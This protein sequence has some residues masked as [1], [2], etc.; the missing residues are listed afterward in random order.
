D[1]R[2]WVYFSARP[3]APVI[4][5]HRLLGPSD[6]SLGAEIEGRI[7]L[8]GTSAV[9]LRDLVSTPL[10]SGLPGVLV[11]AE[12]G[13]QIV[14]GEFITRPDWAPGLEVTAAIGLS[15]LLLAFLPWLTTLANA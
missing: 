14:S 5:V 11:H 9:G 13:D 10:G 15:L 6:P 12:I 3:A 4:P 2:I 1:G 7:V 8:V